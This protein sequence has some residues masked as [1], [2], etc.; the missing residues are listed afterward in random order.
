M[1]NPNSAN[2][3]Y[4]DLPALIIA[5]IHPLCLSLKYASHHLTLRMSSSV[6]VQPLY[7]RKI[8]RLWSGDSCPA[9]SSLHRVSRAR[10]R[11]GDPCNHIRTE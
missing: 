7:T 1:A 2:S 10:Y 5:S 8:S 3:G 4:V 6:L 9:E 11:G